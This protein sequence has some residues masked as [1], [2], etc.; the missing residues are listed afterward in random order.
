MPSEVLAERKRRAQAAARM[1]SDPVELN[2]ID[3]Q[4]LGYLVAVLGTALVY[5]ICRRI[6]RKF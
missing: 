4:T 5:I 1:I 6:G 2:D 3:D